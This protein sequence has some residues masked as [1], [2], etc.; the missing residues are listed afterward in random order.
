MLFSPLLSKRYSAKWQY[1]T[2]L[3]IIIGF[4]IPF[5]PDFNFGLFKVNIPVSI[6]ENNIS[7][8]KDIPVRENISDIRINTN[9]FILN[10]RDLFVQ[11][12]IADKNNIISNSPDIL[13]N[14]AEPDYI[15]K[16]PAYK[17]AF[18]IWVLGAAGVLG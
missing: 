10:N 4:I 13:Q 1:Y 6:P 16:I 14:N 8:S 7:V 9:I 17:I 18:L 3:V 12:N 11:E 15:R 5:R 2:W